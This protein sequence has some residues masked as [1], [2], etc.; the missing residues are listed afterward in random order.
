MTFE[1][2]E[3]TTF[4]IM[5]GT[6]CYKV[7]SFGL[8][9]TGATYQK[10]MVTLFHDMMHKD[11]VYVDDLTVKSREDESHIENLRKLLERL[12]KFQLKLNLAKC[13]FDT[14]FGKLLGFIVNRRGINVDSYKIQAIQNLPPPHTQREVQ[15]FFGRLNY[16]SRFISQMTIKCDP[17][18]KLLKKH[19]LG[20]W[21][22][23][24]QIAFDKV[25]DYLSTPS[26]LVPPFLNNPSFCI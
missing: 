4:V 18:F 19:D 8:K 5:W 14:T 7:M 25:K 13:T 26:I 15:G 12:R 23:E 6:F 21:T 22:E 20:E 2:R 17:I 1:D 16:I 9:N 3:K 11:E 10:A 24:C